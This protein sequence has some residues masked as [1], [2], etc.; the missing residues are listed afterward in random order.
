[1]ATPQEGGAEEVAE[2]IR[3]HDLRDRDRL[4]TV[5]EIAD[6][7]QVKPKTVYTWV[8]KGIIPCIR[9]GKHLVRF[10]REKVDKWLGEFEQRG[11]RTRRLHE[12]GG[13]Q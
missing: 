7:L 1:M 3:Q 11:R 4:L 8:S 10:R 12:P 5:S 6:Y 13:C 9:K 2:G